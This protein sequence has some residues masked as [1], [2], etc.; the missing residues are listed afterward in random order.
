MDMAGTDFFRW[1]TKFCRSVAPTFS[2]RSIRLRWQNSVFARLIGW[3]FRRC[4]VTGLDL[5]RQQAAATR[6]ERRSMRN[7]PERLFDLGYVTADTDECRILVT[8]ESG[9]NSRTGG[10]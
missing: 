2:F 7:L 1:L 4:F 8:V 3:Q 6:R 9:R 5:R 10:I